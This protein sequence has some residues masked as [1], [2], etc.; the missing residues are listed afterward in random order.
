L[1]IVEFGD[2]ECPSCRRAEVH[3]EAIRR[4][5]PE[6][7]AVVRRHFPLSYHPNAYRAARAAECAAQQGRYEDFHAALY[8]ASTADLVDARM[9][10]IVARAQV[11]DASLFAQCV[12]AESTVPEIERDIAKAEELNLRGTPSFI[13][14][15]ILL[16]GIPDSLK[17]QALLAEARRERAAR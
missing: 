10:A 5:Y 13:V 11:P 2:Y 8:R 14:N 12:N 9:E 3:V 15:G 16:G 4:K 6:E 1:T 17:F 7:V